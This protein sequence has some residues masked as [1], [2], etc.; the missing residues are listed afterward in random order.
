MSDPAAPTVL[1]IVH[2][3]HS[4]TGQVGRLLEEQGFRLERRCPNLG[5]ELPRS[6]EPY[7]GVVVFG[8]PMSAN[9]GD[10]MPGMR[11]ELDWIPKVLDARTPFLGICLGAQQL[12][13]VL[14]ARV[15]PHPDGMVEIGY[16]P[17]E[18][19][20]PGCCYF[21]EPMHFYQWHREGFE[22][23]STAKRLAVGRTFENQAFVYDGH[24][25][26][27]QFHP[28]IERSIIERWTSGAASRLSLPGAQPLDA[29]FAGWDRFG[30]AI[31]RWTR[32]LLVRLFQP[33]PIQAAA[34]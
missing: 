19:C 22:V 12:A 7:A 27:L 17:V 28:E 9:D 1:A 5:D 34:D 15:A 33:R 6:P 20:S 13:R 14:G 2:Q 8:G 18:P 30:A 29:H 24:A 21:P 31:E 26:A 32:D 4:T 3:K 23:P 25:V 11:L 16:H 10:C